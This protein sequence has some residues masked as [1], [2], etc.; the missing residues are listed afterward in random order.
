MASTRRKP[1][2]EAD[3]LSEFARSAASGSEDNQARP[4]WQ[5]EIARN[6]V[7]TRCITARAE[8]HIRDLEWRL[9]RLGALVDT[10]QVDRSLIIER[11]GVAIELARLDEEPP[12]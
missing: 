11:L 7:E 1:A 2:A 8:G 12:R 5:G 4:R 10:G 6:R 9:D 3:R